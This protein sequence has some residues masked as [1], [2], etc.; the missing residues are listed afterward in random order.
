MFIKEAH[1]Q[2]TQESGSTAGGRETMMCELAAAH[3]AF[4]DLLNN[5]KEGTKFYND[6]TQVSYNL[7]MSFKLKTQFKC[8]SASGNF[9]KQ[10]LRL[11]LRKEN[12]KGR[13][14]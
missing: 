2:F 12:R 13:T 5:L 10:S 8:L 14:P 7:L 9:P 3:D 6:L 11:Y 1:A 4:R